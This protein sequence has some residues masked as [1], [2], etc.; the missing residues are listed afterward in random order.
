MHSQISRASL[1][2]RYFSMW[3]ALWCYKTLFPYIGVIGEVFYCP[4]QSKDFPGHLSTKN[5]MRLSRT[6]GMPAAFA[7]TRSAWK[8]V[9]NS[10]FVKRS[11]IVPEVKTLFTK[12]RKRSSRIWD[13]S[14]NDVG[15]KEDSNEG[16]EYAK[17]QIVSSCLTAAHGVG[18]AGV[19]EK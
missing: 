11:W 16:A 13:G 5:C 17:V 9:S 12:T 6:S 14:T 3:L 8:I 7:T 19:V 1:V 2:S 15:K 4:I 18:N 10:S